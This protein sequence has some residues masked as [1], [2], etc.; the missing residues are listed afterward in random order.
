M[1]Q[2]FARIERELTELVRRNAIDN[3]RLPNSGN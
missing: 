3:V 2:K 1:I